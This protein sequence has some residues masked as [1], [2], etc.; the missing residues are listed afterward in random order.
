MFCGGDHLGYL[1]ITNAWLNWNKLCMV[2]SMM[3][4]I[5]ICDFVIDI[6]FSTWPL[7]PIIQFD[8]LSFI[9]L[10]CGGGHLWYPSTNLKKINFISGHLK[11]I[12]MDDGKFGSDH[13]CSFHEKTFLYISKRFYVV[14]MF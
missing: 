2:V 13:A 9:T 4:F 6:K 10:S 5:R 1:S 11:I 7:Q 8:W 12:C 3:A 14:K